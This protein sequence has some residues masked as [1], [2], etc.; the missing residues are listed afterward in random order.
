[1]V[2][3]P[4]S[5]VSTVAQYQQAISVAQ[6]LYDAYATGL[7]HGLG[8]DLAKQS[9]NGKNFVDRPQPPAPPVESPK[10]KR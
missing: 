5:A 4:E 10:K 9:F 3:I 1:M 6:K 2:K 8:V 7:A